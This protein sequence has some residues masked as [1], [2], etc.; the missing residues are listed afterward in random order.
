MAAYSWPG[1]VRELVNA[2]E[3]SITAAN[4][5]TELVPRHLPENI[6]I[7]IVLA[8]IRGNNLQE[9]ET[10]NILPLSKKLP[11]LQEARKKAL[12]ELEKKYLN[13]LVLTV[14]GNVKKACEISGLARAQ[15]YNLLKKNDL[16][17]RK[18]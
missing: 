16:S 10:K 1:N 4:D 8:S 7:K 9:E 2:I 5:N 3:W 18:Q 11:V 15:L 6:R 14:D 17:L 13:D 12:A